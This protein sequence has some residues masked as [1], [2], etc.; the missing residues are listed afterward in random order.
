MFDFISWK[1][2]WY[3]ILCVYVPACLG[4]IVV[5]LL[6]KGKG[7]GF[8]GAFGAGGG[9]D[10]VFGPRSSKSLPQRLTYV[11]AGLFMFLA[12]VMSML[13]DKVERGV[14]PELE[15]D[16]EAKAASV[17]EA[18]LTE[19]LD[20]TEEATPVPVAETPEEA[21]DAEDV[22]DGTAPTADAPEEAADAETP[23][24]SN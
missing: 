1:L 22:A 18:A 19:E 15:S 9:S 13:T 10:T 11:M 20:G 3:A 7:V 2:L 8:A 5:V 24:P 16:P 6:Q 4:L 23:A 14:A 21:A 17:I 12:L